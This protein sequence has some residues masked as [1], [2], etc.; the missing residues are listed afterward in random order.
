MLDRKILAAGTL[1]AIL[2]TGATAMA[3]QQYV[4]RSGYAVSGYDVVAYRTMAQ[5]PVGQPQ[6]AAVPGRADIVADW[7]GA[8]WAFASEENRDK[9]LAMPE[10]YVPA[11]DGHCAYGVAQKAKVPAN[12]NLWRIVDDK[13]YLNINQDV[14]ELWEKDVPG[15]IEEAESR[16]GG[17]ER[18]RA[19]RGRVPDLDDSTAP[20]AN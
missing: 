7:N 8:K 11:Y 12:P 16:W 19:S 20:L 3:G 14:V 15:F 17:L 13:L 1:A 6:P 10:Y 18:K 5:A 4:D 2:L 9:F